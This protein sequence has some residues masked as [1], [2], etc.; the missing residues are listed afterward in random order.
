MKYIIQLT[1][2]EIMNKRILHMGVI[3]T[4]LYLLLY[5]FAVHYSAKNI[6]MSS[7][8]AWFAQQI[9]YQMLTM[10]W[11]ISTFLCGAL[12]VLTG[13]GS[14]ASEIESGT[15]LGLA[16]KPVSRRAIVGGKF[17]AYTIVT[18]VYSAVLLGAVALLTGYFFKLQVDPIALLSGIGLFMLFPV[19]LLALAHLGSARFSTLATGVVTFMLFALAIIGGF[20]EQIGAMM[21]NA[22]M[23]NIGVVSSLVIPSDAIYRLA[24]SVAVGPMGKSSIASFGPF[25]AASTPSTVMLIYALVYII[26]IL[27]LAFRFFGKRDF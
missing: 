10:G 26:I 19:I 14:L 8:E 4:L 15:I 9:G 13:A 18:A 5:G 24:V 22:S 21:E 25:G 12:A 3:M 17:L 2:K 1:L 23:I 27:A 16:S 11:Y 6:A 20:I 7:M